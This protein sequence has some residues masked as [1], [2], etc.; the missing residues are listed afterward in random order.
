[1]ERKLK[2]VSNDTASIKGELDRNTY[3]GEQLFIHMVECKP[4]ISVVENKNV[5]VS[6]LNQTTL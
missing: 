3:Q 2:T 4:V 1:M 6:D 5:T